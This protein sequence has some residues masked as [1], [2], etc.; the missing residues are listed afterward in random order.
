MAETGATLATDV[1]IW[2]GLARRI[3]IGLG[4]NSCFEYLAE[5]TR[6]I[7]FS[8]YWKHLNAIGQNCSGKYKEMQVKIV[9]V[10]LIYRCIFQ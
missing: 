1:L 7:A 10:H 2:Q 8:L 6:R 9:T 3:Q 5:T 4:V